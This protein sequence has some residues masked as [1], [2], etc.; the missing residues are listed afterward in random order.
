MT[1]ATI[2]N[3][4]KAEVDK[5]TTTNYSLKLSGADIRKL[6][7]I[8]LSARVTFRVPGGGDWSNEIIDLDGG[9]AV[10]VQW[11][12]VVEGDET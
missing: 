9:H 5:E 2:L 3:G 11:Q 10:D 6:L 4:L 12:T 1:T 7:D 8:P